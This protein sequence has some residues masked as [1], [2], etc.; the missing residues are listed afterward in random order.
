MDILTLFLL[1]SL[2]QKT[3]FLQNI[4]PILQSLKNSEDTLKFLSDLKNFISAFDGFGKDNQKQPH[5]E[6]KQDTANPKE[7]EKQAQKEKG[8]S[9]FQGIA[10]E[11]L[12]EY[13]DEYLKGK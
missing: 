12:Q 6:K 11:L 3:D 10:D 1:Y 8:Q 9:P 5:E 7:N 4:Q 13:L 2:S